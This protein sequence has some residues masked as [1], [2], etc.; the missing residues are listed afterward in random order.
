MTPWTADLILKMVGSILEVV[1][2]KLMFSSPDNRLPLPW[3]LQKLDWL[4]YIPA[5]SISF[6]RDYFS[7]LM[8]HS[9]QLHADMKQNLRPVEI[10]NFFSQEGCDIFQRG[11]MGLSKDRGTPKWMLHNK[12]P[13]K[14]DDLGVSLFL[15]TSIL[16]DVSFFFTVHER[17]ENG[18][19][20]SRFLFPEDAEFRPSHVNGSHSDPVFLLVCENGNDRN[21]AKGW[22]I[23]TVINRNQSIY[24]VCNSPKWATKN[25]LQ[26]CSTI[27]GTYHVSPPSK[28][29]F[30]LTFFWR[31]LYPSKTFRPLRN[32][33]LSG[34]WE[35]LYLGT[36]AR[37]S[38][39]KHRWW[40][41]L[42]HPK[43]FYPVGNV[44]GEISS[45]FFLND[46]FTW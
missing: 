20:F 13:I 2:V 39:V 40:T 14:M 37:H 11:Y 15:E 3:Y 18:P 25:Y 24:K 32:G 46:F 35:L 36:L 12:H 5:Y 28:W 8:E 38:S 33:F 22:V 1:F 41:H 9:L 16:W 34:W 31:H 27:V 17:L 23:A 30:F 10:F 43:N 21:W 26:N 7:T 4:V 44:V 19:F 42:P 29:D 6:D 45:S